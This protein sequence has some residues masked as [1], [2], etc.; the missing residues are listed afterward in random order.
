MKQ[1]VWQSEF[2]IGTDRHVSGAGINTNSRSIRRNVFSQL[3]F[4]H[5]MNTIIYVSTTYLLKHR[6]H[7]ST[8]H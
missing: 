5:I 4:G 1:V 3:V 6:L 2:R 7:V 8:Q